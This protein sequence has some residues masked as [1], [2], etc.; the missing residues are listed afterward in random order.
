MFQGIVSHLVLLKRA[1]CIR[2]ETRF[3]ASQKSHGSYSS[4]LYFLTDNVS[5]VRYIGGGIRG[6]V[7]KLVDLNWESS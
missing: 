6:T 4:Q 7:T 2:V 3:C 5:S 1:R